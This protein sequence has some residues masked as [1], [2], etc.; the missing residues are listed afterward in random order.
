[1]LTSQMYMYVKK[2]FKIRKVSTF[3]TYLIINFKSK[4]KQNCH[5]HK[6]IGRNTRPGNLPL[7]FHNTTSIIK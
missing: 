2:I 5:K 7:L 1:M 4:S 3:D 6:I